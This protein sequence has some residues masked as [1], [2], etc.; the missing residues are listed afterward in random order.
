MLRFEKKNGKCYRRLS[1][2]RD[3]TC[4]FVSR[5]KKIR[6]VSIIS[7]FV[8]SDRKH[9]YI[10]V[11]DVLIINIINI[12]IKTEYVSIIVF[13]SLY[14]LSLEIGLRGNISSVCDRC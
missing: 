14:V 7:V 10:C 5:V 11:T 3:G 4:A 12:K 2:L 9:A 1:L 13:V 6:Y 8:D